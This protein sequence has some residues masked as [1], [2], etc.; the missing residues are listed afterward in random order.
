VPPEFAGKLN[1]YVSAVDGELRLPAGLI[2]T[3][4]GSRNWPLPLPSEPNC[5]RYSPLG[6]N[7][8]RRLL[9]LS[10][11]QTSPLASTAMPP[12]PLN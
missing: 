4:R 9:P 8:S 2:A 1:F 12:G 7:F 3:S 11:T 6:L 10:T 5:L